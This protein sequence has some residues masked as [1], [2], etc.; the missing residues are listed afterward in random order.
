M[1]GTEAL[2]ADD[3]LIFDAGS[4]K[5][6]YDADGSGAGEAQQIALLDGVTTL[7]EADFLIL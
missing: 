4:G 6:Y 1:T 5:L 3:F 2:E 7:S